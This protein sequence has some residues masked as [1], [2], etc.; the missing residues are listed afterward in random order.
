MFKSLLTLMRGTANRAVDAT[1]DQNAL[2][3]LDQQIR[4]CGEAVGWARKALAV[5]VAQNRQE[6][7]RLQKISSQ[8][9]DLEER[10]G[11]ALKAGKEDLA[12]EAAEAIASLENERDSAS[13]TLSGFSKECE[14]LRGMVR[15]SEVRLKDLE[16]GRRAAKANDA[17]LKLRDKGLIAGET[18]RNTLSE[19]ET[20]LARLQSRQSEIDHATDVLEE[21]EAESNPRTISERMADAGFGSPSRKSANDVLERLKAKNKSAKPAERTK[22]K[23]S[24]P[25]AA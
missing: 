7:G 1:I 13:K 3:I 6:Q 21:L 12:L 17:V 15:T 4:D 16:S 11:L 2:T 14:R 8:I 20:T 25:D 5:A 9:A 23:S 18:Y 10:A 19:A 24:R 22:Q